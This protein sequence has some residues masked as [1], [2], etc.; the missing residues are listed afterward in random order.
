MSSIRIQAFFIPQQI[1]YKN[2]STSLYEAANI[3]YLLCRAAM[4]VQDLES[5]VAAEDHLK[6]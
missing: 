2:E 3:T 4:Q 1:I 5:K 6:R